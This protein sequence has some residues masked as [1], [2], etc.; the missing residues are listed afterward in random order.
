M[1]GPS[2]YLAVEQLQSFIG[3]HIRAVEG[4][5]KIGK[6]RLANQQILTIFSHGKVLMFQFD[7]FALRVHFLLYGSFEATVDEVKVTGDYPKKERPTRLS[8]ILAHGRIDMYSCSLRF[9]EAKDAKHTFDF[10]I[11]IMSPCWNAEKAYANVQ[12]LAHEEI[13]DVLLDQTIFAGV[14]NIIKNEVLILAGVSPVTLVE[15]LSPQKIKEIIT[16]CQNYVFKFYQW[17]K[18]FVLKQHY[19]VYR[20]SFCKMCGH[21]VKRTRTGKRKRFSYICIVCQQG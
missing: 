21:R 15:K 11:D 6:E 5:T 14:G 3:Q 13:G 16:T 4:N 7:T 8:L 2:I 1:E 17:R 10:S 9:I 12:K 18:K 20:Q 19:Q